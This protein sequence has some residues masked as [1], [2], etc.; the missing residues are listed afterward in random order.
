MDVDVQL[1]GKLTVQLNP[2][3]GLHQLGP[4]IHSEIINDAIQMGIEEQM[5][6]FKIQSLRQVD[7]QYTAT[8]DFPVLMQS[9]R[10]LIQSHDALEQQLRELGVAPNAPDENDAVAAPSTGSDSPSAC[11]LLA[12]ADPSPSGSP[13]EGSSGVSAMA[14][15]VPPPVPDRSTIGT[16]NL[17]DDDGDGDEMEPEEMG[18]SALPAE[19]DSDEEGAAQHSADDGSPSTTAD[20]GADSVA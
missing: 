14:T 4:E 10:N 19:E 15:G 9:I 3:Q 5:G 11:P 16:S 6:G 12:D 17:S 13:Q 8:V 2:P 7:G 18:Y 20:A 1:H